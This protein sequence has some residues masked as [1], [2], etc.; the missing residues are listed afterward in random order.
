MKRVG[1]RRYVH[2]SAL[3]QLPRRD[4][5]RVAALA[6]LVPDFAWSVARVGPD[7]MLGVTT[8][9]EHNDHPALVA[10]ITRR[11]D[12]L[13][14]RTYAGEARPIYHRCETMLDANHPRYAHFAR[15]SDREQAAG[16]LS[17]PDVGTVG[18]WA[19]VNPD[20]VVRARLRAT[21]HRDGTVSHYSYSYAGWC[22]TQLLALTWFDIDDMPEP[23]QERARAAIAR[24]GA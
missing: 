16:K 12:A 14:A 10:S 5:A 24:A 22:R 6:R 9:W 3:A 18:A 21:F 13:H 23:S 20:P 8:S 11:G 1:P 19:R 17:R 4:Q 7:V 15:L 2:R